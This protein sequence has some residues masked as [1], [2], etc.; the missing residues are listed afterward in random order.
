MSATPKRHVA[1]DNARRRRKSGVQSPSTRRSSSET[2]AIDRKAHV[3]RMKNA[4]VSPIIIAPC[5]GVLTFEP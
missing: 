3:L 5:A 4:A 1:V 2:P